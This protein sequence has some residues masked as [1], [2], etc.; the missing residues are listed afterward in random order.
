[1]AGL[2][3]LAEKR[4]EAIEADTADGEKLKKKVRAPSAGVRWRFS[5]RFFKEIEFF[6]LDGAKVSNTWGLSIFEKL[7]DL[8]EKEIDELRRDPAVAQQWRYHPINWSSKNIPVKKT[9]LNWITKDYRDND[10][11]FPLMQFQVSKGKG[12]I[13]GFFDE[14]NV[15]QIVLLDPLHNMQPSKDFGY[16]VDPCSPLNCELTQLRENIKDTLAGTKLECGCGVAAKVAVALEAS[17]YG[18]Y[19]V[20]M[21]RVP[22]ET[23]LDDAEDLIKTG[24]AANYWA[25]FQNGIVALAA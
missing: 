10:E 4:G 6:G 18:S 8:G 20:L 7:K 5:F 2:K 17:G 12:R 23:D 11:E 1:M 14:E 19:P 25:I 3:R 22:D 13:I 15:F 21:L 16:T 9:D 24:K